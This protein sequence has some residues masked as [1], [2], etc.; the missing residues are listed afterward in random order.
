MKKIVSLFIIVATILCLSGCGNKKNAEY[1]LGLGAS[2]N[3]VTTAKDTVQFD[4]VVAAVV[5]DSDGKI[6]RCR[7]DEVQSQVSVKGGSVDA[8]AYG[9]D[10][11]TKQELGNGYG[12]KDASGIKKEWYEQADYFAAY[13]IGM[14]AEQ[15]GAISTVKG[16]NGH[17]AATDKAITSGCTIAVSD[18][19]AAIVK[20]AKQADSKRF[21]SSAV[22][23]GLAVKSRLSA[24]ASNATASDNGKV[25]FI[26]DMSAVV[27]DDSK[28]VAAAIVDT[29]EPQI[30]FDSDGNTTTAADADFF[31]KRELGDNYGMKVN[32]AI[33]KEWYEQAAAF[34]NYIVGLDAVGINSMKT[35]VNDHGA[36][37]TDE[38]ALKAGCTI[39][40]DGFMLSAKKAVESVK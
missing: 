14:T 38:A 3:A 4:T 34:E 29:I 18:F 33:G 7:L 2:A 27:T 35:V 20:G 32:S 39:S 6:V 17:L 22:N 36:T 28:K 10:F 25:K 23:L 19:I 1:Y 31:T 26:I 24:D 30:T 16:E 37:V 8:D 11:A 15:V 12:M 9:S 21:S 5:T 40:V 13:V